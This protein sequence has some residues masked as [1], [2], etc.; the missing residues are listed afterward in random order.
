MK[1]IVFVLSVSILV[2]FFL[3]LIAFAGIVTI[4]T[5]LSPSNQYR[6]A[7]VTSTTRDATSSD[8]SVYNTFVSDVAN[9]IPELNALGTTWKA[10]GSTATVDA[11]DNTETNPYN[12]AHVSVPIFLLNDTKLVDSNDDLWDD[13]IDLPLDITEAGLQIDTDV[14]TGSY[15]D[16]TGSFWV[17][18][19]ISQELGSTDSYGV[20]V[21]Y[22]LRSDVGWVDRS[23]Y[24]PTILRSFYALSAPLNVPSPIPEPST[25]ILFSI[26]ILSIL[27]ITYHRRRRATRQSYRKKPDADLYYARHKSKTELYRFVNVNR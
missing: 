6:L 10:V 23:S 25:L 13:S 24:Q 27:G 14:W 26:A 9:A 17:F 15:S 16:G 4:P 22:S 2:L 20:Q 21:G 12:A 5:S 7:F 18:S 8:I 1:T 11:R 3:P 19:Q